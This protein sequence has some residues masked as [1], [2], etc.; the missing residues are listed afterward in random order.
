MI[1]PKLGILGFAVIA[2]SGCV[3][4]PHYATGRTLLPMKTELI[5]GVDNL[6]IASSDSGEIG[7]MPAVLPQ[8]GLNLGLPGRFEVG[9][10]GYMSGIFEG[11]LRWQVNPRSY[12]KFDFSLDGTYG[13]IGD[14]F[15]Y[16]KYGSTISKTFDDITPYFYY[17]R[18]DN[19]SGFNED[20]DQDIFDDIIEGVVEE[21][22][23]AS[24]NVGVGIEIATKGKTA[25]IPEIQYQFY[26]DS[27]DLGFFTFGFCIKTKF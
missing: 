21:L 9:A 14:G 20:D 18:I 3:F 1:F 4:T 8:V 24:S 2:L 10:N 5:I 16:I 7:V 26:Q 11:K 6:A 17:E 12:E 23:D 13:L 22:S 19:L 15:T 27:L 25:I